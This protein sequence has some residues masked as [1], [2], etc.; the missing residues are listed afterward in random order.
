VVF[1]SWWLSS[2]SVPIF[3]NVSGNL[4]WTRAFWLVL[5]CFFFKYL[6]RSVVDRSV[7]GGFVQSWRVSDGVS[8]NLWWTGAFPAICAIFECFLVVFS[9]VWC[10][11]FL[12]LVRFCERG[13]FLVIFLE[14]AQKVVDTCIRFYF[15]NSLLLGFI[16]TSSDSFG[17]RFTGK[18]Y[19]AWEFQFRLFVMGKE[20][21]GQIDGSDPA[22]TEPKELAKWK[23]KDARVMS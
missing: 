2:G 20:L 11:Y 15:S 17:V 7:S 16:M 23:V 19:S 1:V 3:W 8:N 5:Y 4:W 21:W 14:V 22:P 13:E 9:T 18:N 10:G 6:Q 12:V